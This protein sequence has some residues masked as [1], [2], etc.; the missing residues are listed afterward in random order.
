MHVN[1]HFFLFLVHDS[2]RTITTTYEYTYLMCG[3]INPHLTLSGKHRCS[4][5]AGPML[6]RRLWHFLRQSHP[7]KHEVWN[8]VVSIMGRGPTRG[9]TLKQHWSSYS[10]LLGSSIFIPYVAHHCTSTT[11]HLWFYRMFY[12][13]WSNLYIY[14]GLYWHLKE[15]NIDPRNRTTSQSVICSNNK[16]MW[17]IGLTY[18]IFLAPAVTVGETEGAMDSTSVFFGLFFCL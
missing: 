4:A 15:I 8:H 12:C 7:S 1:I 5:A 10:W 18:L 17:L 11:K 9:L 2:G 3:T 13:I 6:D 14:D 16:H